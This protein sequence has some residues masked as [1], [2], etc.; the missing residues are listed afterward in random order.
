LLWLE[1]GADFQLAVEARRQAAL[2]PCALPGSNRT[3]GIF[4]SGRTR[5]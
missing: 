2:L 1:Q 5:S 3:R 4:G